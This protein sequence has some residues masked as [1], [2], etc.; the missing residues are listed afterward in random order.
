MAILII[1]EPW[2]RI[3]ANSSSAEGYVQL[4]STEGA[5]LVGVRS[6]ATP[7]IKIRR[8]GNRPTPG[9]EIDLPAG[10]TV[11]LAPGRD[12]FVLANLKRALKLGDRIAWVLTIKTADGTEQDIRVNAEIRRR[13]PTDDHLHGHR[14]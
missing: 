6:D 3:S 12:R 4:R 8:G 7:N 14:H 13:S 10:E 5:T 1:S 2:V 9:R 11:M